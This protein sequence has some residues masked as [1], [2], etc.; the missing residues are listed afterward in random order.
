MRNKLNYTSNSHILYVVFFFLKRIR[1]SLL[2][3]LKIERQSSMYMRDIQRAKGEGEGED[4][5][6][7]PGISTRLTPH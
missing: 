2:L 7:H 3:V 1:V 5:Q 6:A 4:Q